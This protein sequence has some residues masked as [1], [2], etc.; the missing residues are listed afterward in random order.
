MATPKVYLSKKGVMVWATLAIM[1]VI[2]V[3]YF[4]NGLFIPGIICLCLTGIF[5]L[6]IMFNTKYTIDTND[7]L[8]VKCGLLVNLL[9]PVASIKRIVPTKTIFSAPALSL[10]R[11][12]LFYGQYDSVV[13]SPEQKEEFITL[14]RSINP[15]IEYISAR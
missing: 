9:V 3:N 5:I 6:P 8:Q 4:F 12:E 15:A 2:E 1:I 11:L 13:I 10:D 7:V 14:L